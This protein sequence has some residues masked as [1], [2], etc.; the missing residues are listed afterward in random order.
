MRTDAQAFVFPG[1]V[2]AAKLLDQPDGRCSGGAPRRRRS[3][4]LIPFRPQTAI[5]IRLGT[6][7]CSFNRGRKGRY[8]FV[9]ATD[10]QRPHGGVSHPCRNSP[11]R[12]GTLRRRRD[13]SAARSFGDSRLKRRSSR[14]KV[15]S[16]QKS[17]PKALFERFLVAASSYRPIGC[18][19]NAPASGR[20]PGDGGGKNKHRGWPRAWIRRGPPAGAGRRRAHQP[21]GSR[22]ISGWY[23]IRRHEL[24][25]R[26][27][28]RGRAQ[29]LAG[30]IRRCTCRC[31]RLR[32]GLPDG[33]FGTHRM[34]QMARDRI[35]PVCDQ[36]L[37]FCSQTLTLG[38]RP[39]AF[40]GNWCSNA[41]P[42]SSPRNRRRGLYQPSSRK[43]VPRDQPLHFPNR[44]STRT[45][46][47]PRRACSGTRGSIG[48]LQFDLADEG[49]TDA[50]HRVRH[51]TDK[52][53]HG[54]QRMQA[55]PHEPQ[56]GSLVTKPIHFPR[57]SPMAGR[58]PIVR[59][60]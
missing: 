46:R 8:G 38:R 2:D 37:G 35:R 17:R 18:V 36:Q 47:A 24:G 4:P 60:W 31:R 42:A 11:V 1:K 53:R 59:P 41:C 54:L 27:V 28:R 16:A 5:R 26:V 40:T 33:L 15:S 19:V 12:P 32:A 9:G 29:A 51:V 49:L 43:V 48:A 58:C 50:G 21:R 6:S 10:S 57:S 45:R 3:S 44:S 52:I 20:S 23:N 7:G 22:E 30:T 25:I 34:H 55:R 13:P 14:S 56:V 39:S